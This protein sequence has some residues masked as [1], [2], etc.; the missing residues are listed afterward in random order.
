[1]ME[2]TLDHYDGQSLSK[3]ER[4]LPAERAVAISVGGSTH[5]VMMASPSDLEDFAYGFLLADGA[6]EACDDVDRVEI[7]QVPLGL[8]VQVR[9]RADLAETYRARKRAMA[10]PVGCGLCGVESLELAVPD[11]PRVEPIALPQDFPFRALEVLQKAQKSRAQTGAL[12][13][14][15]LLDNKSRVIFAREDIGRHNAVDKVI[16]AALRAGLPMQEYALVVSSR[17][18]LDLVIKAV[19]AGIPNLIARASPSDLA[20]QYAQ[21]WRLRLIAPVFQEEYFQSGESDE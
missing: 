5:A 15:A 18:S 9:L 11:L 7:V 4:A 10:G 21:K 17:V 19:R 14:A 8:D 3:V 13:G 2:K 1:M 16:G 6:I 12:H 20:V